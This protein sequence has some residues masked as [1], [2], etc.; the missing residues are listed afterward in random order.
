[1]AK[2]FIDGMERR[3]LPLEDDDVDAPFRGM[4]RGI[5]ACR[6]GAADQQG[7]ARPDQTFLLKGIDDSAGSQ[8][9]VADITRPNAR[10]I[11]ATRTHAV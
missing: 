6:P 2:G 7:P 3:F 11:E 10:Q 8:Q 9:L 5:D 1:M 4:H